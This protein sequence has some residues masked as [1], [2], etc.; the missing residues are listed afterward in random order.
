[1][2]LQKI[3]L[4]LVATVASFAFTPALRADTH[5]ALADFGVSVGTPD[6]GFGFWIGQSAPHRYYYP[7]PVYREYGPPWRHRYVRIVPPPTVVVRPPVAASRRL[8][9]WHRPR[10]WSGSDHY[11]LDHEFQRLADLGA[12]HSAGP[13]VHRTTGR[14]L[15]P[16]ADQ[17]AAS[18]RVRLLT[19]GLRSARL[20]LLRRE[21]IVRRAPRRA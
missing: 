6:A 21:H 9:W 5:V 10:R 16:D 14:V 20:A 1:M 8:R 15:R 11:G 2:T 4:S 3:A 13:V 17:R 7:G 12:D 19:A 18:A